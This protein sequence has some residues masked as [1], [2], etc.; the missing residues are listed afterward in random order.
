MPV[1]PRSQSGL[2]EFSSGAG[3]VTL[4]NMPSI[5]F[6]GSNTWSIEVWVYLDAL[7]DQMNLVSRQGEFALVTQG[8]CISAARQSQIFPLVST[9][10]LAPH[11]W[12]H[13]CVTFDGATMSLFLNG[14]RRNFITMTDSGVANQGQ[15]MTIGGGFYGQTTGARFWNIALPPDIIFERQWSRYAAN[16]ANLM[17]QIDFTQTPPIDT[18]GQGAPV[19]VSATGVAYLLYTPAANL[20]EGAFCDPYNDNAVNPGGSAA[21]FTVMAW[22]SPQA[23]PGKQAIFSNGLY[24]AAGMSLAINAAGK[25]EFQIGGATAV[26]S[27]TALQVNRWR[28]VTA[29]WSAAGGNAAIF[30][31]GVQD[32]TGTMAFATARSSGA[33]LVGA[34]ATSSAA[35]PSYNFVGYIQA[36]SLWSY[37]LTAAQIQNYM[38]DDPINDANCIADYDFVPPRAQ[39]SWSLNPVG[40]VGNAS[41]V[42]IRSAGTVS[43]NTMAQRPRPPLLPVATHMTPRNVR[44]DDL[45]LDTRRAMV[46]E[47]RAFM[48]E[49]LGLAPEQ[50][51]EF[52]ARFQ[53][54]LALRAEQLASGTYRV[55]FQ[56][57]VE[58]LAGDRSRL[59]LHADGESTI[60]YEGEFD[61]CTTWAIQFIISL[62]LTL[63]SVFSFSMNISKVAAGLTNYLAQRINTIGLVPQLRV[64]FNKGTTPTT[65]YNALEL[66]WDYGLLT[67]TMK[68]LW[69]ATSASV[70]WW[71]IGSIA[72]RIGLL[73]SPFA[74]LEVAVFITELA[75]SI[76]D[77][78]AAWN[79]PNNCWKSGAER[80]VLSGP[81]G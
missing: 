15:P 80:R 45:S 72:V 36:V 79:D 19:T 42:A 29:T 66:L 47:F 16:T 49:R 22:I 14:L 18:S 50:Q 77:V 27:T 55:P 53:A 78:R 58:P 11:T 56:F 17:A 23:Q 60:I 13:V 24:G 73:F 4:G 32:A 1:Q 6:Q 9:P 51:E 57:S 41:V 8:G 28:N 2:T 10:L 3:A 12:Y 33:P 35:L 54:N 64:V 38:T 74:P 37:V 67:G 46:A 81:I 68:F 39:N 62:G 59:W 44:S 31:D 34:A 69:Q 48:T 40:I 75:K 5:S 25:I 20:V 76:I 63:Y 71:T 7:V 61:A 30:L 52:A 26:V 65:V 70:S 21:D 43:V